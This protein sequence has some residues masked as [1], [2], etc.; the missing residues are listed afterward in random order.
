MK[1][2]GNLWE[3]FCNVGNAE[4]AI[5]L[6]T[7]NKRSD[8]VV[9][10]K[11]C[12]D[13]I[14]P[15]ERG[16]LDPAKV[17]R[18]AKN[19]VSELE[20]GWVHSPLKQKIVI[21]D[22]GKRRNIDCPSLKDHIIHW[23]LLL[24]IKEPL[25]RG[26]YEHSYGSIPKRGIDG[27]RRTVE[28]WIQ[29]DDKCKYFVKL[30]I[31]K[32]YPSIDQDRLKGMFRRIIKDEKILGVIDQIIDVAPSGL[33]I[34]TYTSQWFAN[35]YLQGLD[36]HIVQDMYKLR[37]GKRIPYVSHYLR[38]MDDML[39]FGTSKRDLEKA[40][41][42]IMRYCREELGLVIK[43]VWEIR[44][45][46]SFARKENGRR[47]LTDGAAPVDIVGYRF[48]REHTEVRSNIY[49]HTQ[50]LAAKAEK[51]LRKRGSILLGHAQAIVSLAGWFTHA[52]SEDYLRNLNSTIKINF[53]RRVISYAAKHGIVG[54]AA[55]I[56]CRA[57]R[58]AG[59]YHILYGR[60]GGRTR[61]RH[62]V[63]GRG[64]EH[65]LPLAADTSPACQ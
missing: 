25:T 7:Q 13:S 18:Y 47:V 36:H 42:E 27:A 3:A 35:F 19:L 1:R 23:M 48:Y 44:R 12:L 45:V 65:E 11:L 63:S 60:S 14:L 4:T 17:R 29:H 28:R 56:Y 52:D 33:P 24:A 41:R 6:G 21:P 55:R 37:R 5:I 9:R 46:A 54:D 22:H 61:K 8:H 20:S 58:R 31:R 59:D 40:V 57:G 32:F 26:M 50:R 64:V 34:G 62:C 51:S 10:R 2:Y 49:L 39:L 38:Y 53:L 16:K 30:D 43:P 15:E